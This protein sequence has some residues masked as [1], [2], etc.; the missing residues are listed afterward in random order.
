MY[1]LIPTVLLTLF[2]VLLCLKYIGDVVFATL[3]T[4]SICVGTIIYFKDRI[5]EINLKELIIKL[6][7]A[8]K[9]LDD[10]N[11]LAKKLATFLGYVNTHLNGAYKQRKEFND[12]LDKFVDSTNATQSE[13]KEIMRKP[14]LVEK[15]MDPSLKKDEQK[16]ITEEIDKLEIF[17]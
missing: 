2:T 6:S 15:L 9:V 8:K 1:I 4:V 17:R 10:I 5:K 16:K 3:V 7:E 12:L 14:R 11:V 13:K